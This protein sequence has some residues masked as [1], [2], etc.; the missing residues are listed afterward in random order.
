[1]A[2]HDIF[3]NTTNIDNTPISVIEAMACSLP[4]CEHKCEGNSAPRE[5]GKTALLVGPGD[6]EGMAAAVKAV[7]TEPDV[8]SRLGS[9]GRRLASP[10]TGVLFCH[11][12]D[13]LMTAAAFE[14]GVH[15]FG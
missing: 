6:V 15:D 1:M 3:V 2:Q 13:R 9:N 5:Q 8:A 4:R 14:T 7:L 11:N 10:L 12:G